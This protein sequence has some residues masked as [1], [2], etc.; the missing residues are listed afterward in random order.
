ML[1]VQ[2]LSCD[3]RLWGSKH[4]QKCETVTSLFINSKALFEQIIDQYGAVILL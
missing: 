3:K 1:L 4:R 2:N